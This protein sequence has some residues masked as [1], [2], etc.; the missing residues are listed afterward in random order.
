[1]HVKG[2]MNFAEEAPAGLTSMAPEQF[3]VDCSQYS[4]FI[5]I[6]FWVSG[7]RTYSSSWLTHR[8]L[9][10]SAPSAPPLG[11]E[12]VADIYWYPQSSA[13]HHAPIYMEGRGRGS[14]GGLPDTPEFDLQIPSE[15]TLKYFKFRG[16]IS[17]LVDPVCPPFGPSWE[18]SQYRSGSSSRVGG[19]N[20]NV[21]NPNSEISSYG[22]LHNSEPNRHFNGQ[23]TFRGARASWWTDKP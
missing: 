2:T 23:V 17:G 6:R 15:T 11:T 22:G 21:G 10:S 7:P 1:M 8:G 14:Y 5:S 4:Y 18:G 12:G 20:P 9:H 13:R 3:K 19:D 16:G